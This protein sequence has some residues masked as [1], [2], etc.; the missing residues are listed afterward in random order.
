MSLNIIYGEKGTGK[1]KYIIDKITEIKKKNSNVKIYVL[2]PEQFSFITEKKIT[3]ILNGTGLNGIEVVTFSKLAS[4]FKTRAIKDYLKPSGKVML[5][6]NAIKKTCQDNNIY[7]GCVTK[8]GFS[9]TVEEIIKEFKRYTITPDILLEISESFKNGI[10]KEKLKAIA[11]IYKTY[12]NDSTNR[13]VDS[14]NDLISLYHKILDEN[15]FSDS[16]F[17]ID[18]FADFLPQHYYVIEALVKQSSGIYVTLPIVDENVDDIFSIPKNTLSRLISISKKN[19]IEY[20][21]KKLDYRNDYFESPEMEFLYKNYTSFKKD[22]FKPYNKKTDDIKIFAATDIYSEVEYVAQKINNLIET[23]GINFRDISVVCGNTDTYNHIVEAVFPQ[24]NIPFFSDRKLNVSQHP[25]ITTILGVFEIFEKNWSYES[26]FRFLKNGFIYF[27]NGDELTNISP[28]DID[29]L[30][31]YV[32]KRGIKGRKKWTT[33]EDWDYGAGG[34]ADAI[35]DGK[36]QK[37]YT[38][39]TQI[40]NDLRRKIV[41]PIENLRAKMLRKNNVKDLSLALFE[42]L[43]EINL[44][45]GLAFEIEKLN[46]NGFINEAQQYKQIWDIILEVI[47]QSVVTLNDTHCTKDEYAQY[48]RSGF[49]ECEISIIPTSVDAVTVGSA[50][51]SMQKNVKALF[52]VGALR[53]D[54]PKEET[55]NGIFTDKERTDLSNVLNNSGFEIGKNLKNKKL[56]SEFKLFRL[57]FT[58]KNNLFISYPVNNFEGET[59]IPSELIFN[60][61]KIFSDLDITDNISD[62]YKYEAKTLSPKAAFDYLLENKNNKNDVSV[63]ELY[64]WFS[65]HDDWKDKLNMANSYDSFY[66]KKIEISKENANELYKRNSSYSVSRLSEFSDCPFKYFIK[67]GLKAKPQEIWQIQKFDLGT[68]MH[69]AILRY[70]QIIENGAKTFDELKN[71]W[72]TITEEKSNEIID[73]IIADIRDKIISRLDRDE[74]KVNYLIDRMTKT[75]KRSVKTVMMSLNNGEYVTAEHEKEF[76]VPISFEDDT[77]KIKGTIDRIDVSK[78]SDN[79]GGIRIIDYKSGKKDFSV[80]SISNMQDIQLVVYSI[81]AIDLYNSGKIRYLEDTDKAKITGL[82]YNKL[83]DDM[84]NATDVEKINASL[85]NAM[86]LSGPVILDEVID[87]NGEAISDIENAYLMDKDIKDKKTSDYLSITLTKNGEINKTSDFF[88]RSEFD[89]ISEYVKLN[90]IKANKLIKDGY[91]DIMPSKSGNNLACDYCDMAEICLFDAEKNNVRNLCTKK[92]DAWELINNT[93]NKKQ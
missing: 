41:K 80:V 83:R 57:L 3:S 71:N 25:I 33:C 18:E 42:F 22:N 82:M 60:L 74:G 36:F 50:D 35:Q 15:L 67:N 2:V 37:D 69:Y 84:L 27:K 4:G 55:E 76:I 77:V 89:K 93:I 88:T 92:E 21:L 45:E 79:T 12:E 62:K 5:I 7:S 14:D 70:S 53:G 52:I 66:N 17:F 63:R 61:S 48:I 10:M 1:S 85:E 13:F 58:A 46:N 68:L 72:S 32:Q 9:K 56:Q 31:S 26:V 20:T 11:Q 8:T 81:C 47:N 24:Y 23:K 64:K 6:Q 51:F 44:R 39:K 34:I 19:N 59:Q 16:F 90:I 43:E 65:N 29:L 30:E 49:S 73:G 86:K 87:D 54:I 28:D 40:I 75:I 78:L 38:L 91:I